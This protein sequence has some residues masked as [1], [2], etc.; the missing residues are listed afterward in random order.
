MFTTDFTSARKARRFKP[1]ARFTVNGPAAALQIAKL[2][3]FRR[4]KL[5]NESPKRRFNSKNNI[6]LFPIMASPR[7]IITAYD[8]QFFLVHY[9]TGIIL[10]QTTKNK[11]NTNAMISYRQKK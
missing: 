7:S 5:N 2:N 1:Y 6:L 9:K 8:L 3:N 11:R 4:H 10:C